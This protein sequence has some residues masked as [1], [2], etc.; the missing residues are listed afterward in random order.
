MFDIALANLYQ[1]SASSE[2]NEIAINFSPEQGIAFSDI[3]PFLQI[4]VTGNAPNDEYL[5]LGLPKNKGFLEVIF[6]FSTNAYAVVS[7]GSTQTV[8]KVKAKYKALLTTDLTTNEQV[9]KHENDISEYIILEIYPL[10]YT[11]WR[12]HLAQTCLNAN[13][14]NIQISPM[15]NKFQIMN[16]IQKRT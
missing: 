2:R 3:E 9:T 7:D 15:P 13:V 1:E 5:A 6:D 10:V 4:F 12:S 14:G 8:F 16:E 11:Q